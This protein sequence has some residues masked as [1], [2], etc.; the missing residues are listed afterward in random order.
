MKKLL[1]TVFL[2]ATMGAGVISVHALVITPA[3]SAKT[4]G[5]ACGPGLPACPNGC[6]CSFSIDRGVC[7][8]R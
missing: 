6:S 5:N 4:C 8:P 2:A 7:M 3:A 1:T